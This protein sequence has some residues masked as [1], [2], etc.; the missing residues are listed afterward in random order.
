MNI[1]SSRRLPRT[2]MAPV[3]L[4]LAVACADIQ[5]TAP[6]HSDQPA[7][8]TTSGAILLECPV[9]TTRSVTATIDLL[10]GTLELDGHRVEIPVNAVLLPTEF[11]LTVPASNYM[12]IRVRAGDAE[13]YEFAEPVTLTVSYERCTRSNIDK[14]EL[15]IYHVDSEGNAILQDMGGTDDKELRRVV[16][17]TDHL[18]DYAIGAP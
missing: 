11:T 16:T 15:R 8:S 6:L 9:D 12:K 1:I 18:S 5:P 17:G 4:A 13:S 3:L 2:L 10:G 14:E 7:L